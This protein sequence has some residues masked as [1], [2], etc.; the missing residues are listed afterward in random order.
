VRDEGTTECYALQ[1][2]VRLGQRLGLSEETAR[3]LM[4]QLLVENPGRSNREYVVPPECRD[5][6]TLDLNPDVATFP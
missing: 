6:G 4:R 5:G 3:R 1:S 2:G